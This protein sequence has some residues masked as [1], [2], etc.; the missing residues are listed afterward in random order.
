[1]VS[2]NRYVAWL[3]PVPFLNPN[4][5]VEVFINFSSFKSKQYSKILDITGHMVIGLK[6]SADAV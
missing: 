3:H 4:C 2:F 1:M 5:R 6:S